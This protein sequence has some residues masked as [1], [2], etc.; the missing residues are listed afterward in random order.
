M[1]A[2]SHEVVSP[3]DVDPYEMF[4]VT[5]DYEYTAEQV[6]EACDA[7]GITSERVMR[8]AEGVLIADWLEDKHNG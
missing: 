7:L 6:K 4:A 1:S 2:S 5:I 8:S 3:E